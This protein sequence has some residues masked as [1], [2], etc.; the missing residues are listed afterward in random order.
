MLASVASPIFLKGGRN[1][2]IVAKE[3]RPAMLFYGKDWY[4]DIRVQEMDYAE[5]GMYLLLCW[6][7]W[8][9]GSIPD[10]G[11]RIARILRVEVGP[12]VEKSF[13]RIRSCFNAVEGRLIHGKVEEIRSEVDGFSQRQR[14]KAN[15]RWHKD[16]PRDAKPMPELCLR[17]PISDLRSP[18]SSE[19]QNP[20]A[21]DKA[22]VDENP[23]SYKKE[24]LAIQQ[25][26][27]FSEW[28]TLYWL[29]KSRKAAR[30]AFGKHIKTEA[31][32]DE[33]MAATKSQS[34]EMLAREACRRIHGATWLNG[35]RWLDEPAEAAPQ[36]R[37]EALS[38]LYEELTQENNGI[39][40]SN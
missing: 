22:R 12:F 17:S 18:S 25:D 34:A 3:K 38:A 30:V 11:E 1:L 9:E 21:F 6:L 33:V 20:C 5:Q 15:R 39:P 35:E 13:S 27:W 26:G 10:D 8:S 32:F 7:C 2:V 40:E 28:W 29:H 4:N 31:R 24:S 14:D 23:L 37:S 36:A 19:S 16:A